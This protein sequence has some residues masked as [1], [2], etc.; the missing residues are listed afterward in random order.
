MVIRE[1]QILYILSVYMQQIAKM[2]K[3][4]DIKCWQGCGAVELGVNG[5]VK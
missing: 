3:T 4:D 5:K 2:E 1:M